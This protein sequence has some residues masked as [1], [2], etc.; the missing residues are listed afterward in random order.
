MNNLTLLARVLGVEPVQSA[1]P[2]PY[3]IV[4]VQLPEHWYTFEEELGKY[5]KEYVE[6]H[7]QML[8]KLGL[9]MNKTNDIKRLKNAMS[10]LSSDL[11]EPIIKYIDEYSVKNGI[12]DLRKETGELVAKAKAMETILVNTQAKRYTQFTCFVCMDEQVSLCLDPC[13]HMMCQRCL[14]RL[15]SDNCPACRSTIDKTIRMYSLV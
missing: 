10:G 12:D 2:L 1:A 7:T 9:L 15:T 8:Q 11:C 13:G 5:K 6:T 14:S 4:E 3:P